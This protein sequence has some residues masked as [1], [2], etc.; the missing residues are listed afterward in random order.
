MSGSS[1]S[2]PLKSEPAL[3]GGVDAREGLLGI[4]EGLHGILF[5]DGGFGVFVQTRSGEEKHRKGGKS[6]FYIA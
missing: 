1:V 5:G 4:R 3:E 6:E 2:R